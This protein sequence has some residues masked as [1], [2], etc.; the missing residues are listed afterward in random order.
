MAKRKL[1]IRIGGMG[2]M[3][4]ETGISRSLPGP[5]GSS[6]PDLVS[7]TGTGPAMNFNVKF[8]TIEDYKVTEQVYQAALD[9]AGDAGLATADT[10]TSRTAIGG[11]LGA[12]TALTAGTAVLPFMLIGVGGTM[13]F[14]PAHPWNILG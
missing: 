9:I 12:L 7:G 14:D 3:P 1:D 10:L 5:I 4:G 6:N 2:Q 8:K 11:G 13:L